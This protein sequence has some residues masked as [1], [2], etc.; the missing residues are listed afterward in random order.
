VIVCILDILF[1]LN[2]RS[3]DFILQFSTSIL[4]LS[5]IEFLKFLGMDA[6]DSQVVTR[7]IRCTIDHHV[8]R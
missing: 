8:D 1:L 2:L 6:N 5:F 7:C 4:G 3:E